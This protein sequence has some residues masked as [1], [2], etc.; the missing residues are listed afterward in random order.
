MTAS[1]LLVATILSFL[2]SHSSRFSNLLRKWTNRLSSEGKQLQK[3]KQTLKDEQLKYNMVDDFAKYSKIQRKINAIDEKLKACNSNQDSI[4]WQLAS[5]YVPQV[6]C[7][8]ILMFLSMYYRSTPL[9]RLP[10]YIDLTPFNYIISYPNERNS[11]SFHFWVM[12]CN[13]IARS[14]KK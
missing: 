10:D 3:E 2:A 11:V 1:L 5:A 12:G 4:W 14:L 6:I 8:L 7:T 9:F 13:I